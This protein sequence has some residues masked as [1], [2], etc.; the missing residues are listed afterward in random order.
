MK[1]LLFDVRDLMSGAQ[2]ILQPGDVG[3]GIHLKDDN[4]TISTEPGV[5]EHRII[6]S[7]GIVTFGV[8]RLFKQDQRNA[9]ASLATQVYNFVKQNPEWYPKLVYRPVFDVSIDDALALAL[10]SKV[11]RA[12]LL[13]SGTK[14]MALLS[15]LNEWTANRY[16]FVKSSEL[17]LLNSLLK[18]HQYP[19]YDYPSKS[20]TEL[21]EVTL[22]DLMDAVVAEM[23][24][25]EPTR[26]EYPADI[27]FELLFSNTTSAVLLVK[28]DRYG[29]ED[30]IAQE[31]FESNPGVQRVVTLR[32]IKST[33]KHQVIVTNASMYKPD[34]SSVTYADTK[35]LN[36]AEKKA[37][38]EAEWKNLKITTLGPRRGSALT[39]DVIWAHTQIK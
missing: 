2:F 32:K 25:L 38:G 37:G 13:L 1:L 8:P 35:E 28:T 9:T 26:R 19:F 15:E 23:E 5:P 24:N 10:L 39:P 18:I 27:K 17:R 31:F 33:T 12:T 6:H 36:L 7:K 30:L 16:N 22:L 34:L 20:R 29:A 21:C 11:H 3:I 4:Q 14:L